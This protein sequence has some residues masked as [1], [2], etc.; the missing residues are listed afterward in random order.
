VRPVTGE[1][2]VITRGDSRAVITELAAS[3]RELVIDGVAVTPGFGDDVIPPYGH[4]IVLVPWPNRIPDGIWTLDGQRMLLDITE[5]DKQNAIHGLLRNTGYTLVQHDKSSVQLSA[6]VFPQHGYPFHLDTSVRYELVDGALQVTH[7]LHNLSDR[8][9]PVAVGAHPYLSI[10]DEPTADLELTIHADTHIEVDA[11]LN[12]IRE[13]DVDGTEWDLRRPRR[14]GD[15]TL[16]DAFGGV[17]TQD[18]V[19]ARLRA[20]DGREV[21]LLQDDAHGFVQ[22]FITD[23]FPGLPTA[24]AIE[25]MTA[26]ANAFNHGDGLRWLQPGET[27]NVGWGIQYSA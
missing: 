11:R 22:C 24:I 26:P 5:P 4:G 14:V 23:K 1:Q 6:V 20:A 21:R 25:P 3:L 15:L 18:G 27:W 13:H 9:A 7:E 17:R 19:S 2:Y 10:G 12:H 8:P 16:D